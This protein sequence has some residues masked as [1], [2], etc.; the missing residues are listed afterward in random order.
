MF[1]TFMPHKDNPTFSTIAATICALKAFGYIFFT[2]SSMAKVGIV[3]MEADAAK[4]QMIWTVKMFGMFYFIMAL[5]H[6]QPGYD[7]VKAILWSSSSIFMG[8]YLLIK[9]DELV[10]FVSDPAMMKNQLWISILLAAGFWSRCRGVLTLENQVTSAL[11]MNFV[12]F[13]F[14]PAFAGSIYFPKV[15]MSSQLQVHTMMFGMCCFFFGRFSSQDGY[16]KSKAICHTAFGCFFAYYC[17]VMPSS[18]TDMG[19]DTK[20]MIPWV[21]VNLF[22]GHCYWD[23]CG[24]LDNDTIF[25]YIHLGRFFLFTF[26][27]CFAKS[28]YFPS[29]GE[30]SDPAKSRFC[31]LL[32]MFGVLNLAYYFIAKSAGY[33]RVK[34][35]TSAATSIL[36]LKYSLTAGGAKALSDAGASRDMVLFLS[37]VSVYFTHHF[38]GRVTAPKKNELS[39][40]LMVCFVLGMIANQPL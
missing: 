35:V 6:L 11:T 32:K 16:E 28:I 7:K 37:V 20:V 2:D 13:T 26:N 39:H 29:R 33:N 34:F 36:S 3:S 22:W 40:V 19:L 25:S 14:F 24:G 10:V 30:S 27:T 18:A 17:F 23:R 15:L 38:Y 21:F 4:S 1:S 31:W 8:Y 5:M 9:P 12:M